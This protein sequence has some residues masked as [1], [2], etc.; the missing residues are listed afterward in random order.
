MRFLAVED[1]SRGERTPELAQVL[2]SA[3]PD[4]IA[5]YFEDAVADESNL[6]AIALFQFQCFHDGRG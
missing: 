6:D 3:L 4:A 5:V 2:Q 1:E